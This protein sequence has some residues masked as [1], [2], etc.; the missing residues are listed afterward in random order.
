MIQIDV[1][2]TIFLFCLLVG[3][4]L[5]LISVVLG[6]LL[7][8]I[9]DA[10]GLDHDIGGSGVVPPI[11]AFVSLFGAGGLFASQVLDL[12]GTASAIVGI[13]A[14]TIGA[15]SVGALFRALRQSEA[16]PEFELENVIGSTG[17]VKVGV[18]PTSVGEV[19]VVAM[20]APRNF[21]ATSASNCGPGTLVRVTAVAG[22][23]LVVEPMTAAP[24][25]SPSAGVDQAGT[26]SEPTATPIEP[27]PPTT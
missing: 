12:D 7:G 5:L 22:A 25:E 8:G 9:G 11:L 1:S 16:G 24:A 6:E 14:G 10:V 13:L 26:P 20:G 18:G 23:Q 27:P 3:G 17:R 2:D 4:G 21:S 15:V 19:E